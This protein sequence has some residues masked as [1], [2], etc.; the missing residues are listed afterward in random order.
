[1]RWKR[2]EKKIHKTNKSHSWKRY[3][4]AEAHW[5]RGSP[6]SDPS[7][8]G[9][10]SVCRGDRTRW[11]SIGSAS[12]HRDTER[13]GVRSP[14]TCSPCITP[15]WGTRSRGCQTHRTGQTKQNKPW[16]NPEREFSRDLRVRPAASASLALFGQ[17]AGRSPRGRS[18]PGLR[19]G[20]GA[21]PAVLTLV[22]VG[23][24]GGRPAH[25]QLPGGPGGRD[26]PAA[27]VRG[28]PGRAPP[29]ARALADAVPGPAGSVCGAPPAAGLPLLWPGGFPPT[30]VV[31][32][33]LGSAAGA[34]AAAVWASPAS[35]VSALRVC[36]FGILDPGGE[37]NGRSR[38]S[39]LAERQGVFQ[40]ISF[41]LVFWKSWNHSVPLQFWRIWARRRRRNPLSNG[42][43]SLL[44]YCVLCKKKEKAAKQWRPT[45]PAFF[46]ASA[47]QSQCLFSFCSG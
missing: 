29:S 25:A 21:F 30:Q 17:G 7:R 10:T 2:K 24:A 32:P 5:R 15:H 11:A 38:A 12:R 34:G 44:K 23:G 26:S 14:G 28:S 35:T 6:A 41:M 33:V 42:V 19:V 1:M 13:T 46:Q 18:P 20:E 40:L 8:R 37:K 45:T 3:V 31:T 36:C 47:P 43:F 22:P 16:Q 27:P 9:D 4:Y 39:C